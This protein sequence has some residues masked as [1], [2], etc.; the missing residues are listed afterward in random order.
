MIY[1]FR[2]VTYHYRCH[3]ASCCTQST[4]SYNFLLSKSYFFLNRFP[5]FT[6]NVSFLFHLS[7]TSPFTITLTSILNVSYVLV[8]TVGLFYYITLCD[9]CSTFCLYLISFQLYTNVCLSSSQSHYKH[10]AFS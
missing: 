7:I 8:V 1:N 6:Q 4:L 5:L 9:R 2:H 10:T 3:T